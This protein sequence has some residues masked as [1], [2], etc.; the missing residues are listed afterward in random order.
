MLGSQLQDKVRGKKPQIGRTG[1]DMFTVS[2]VLTGW[3]PVI[4]VPVRREEERKEGNKQVHKT[5]GL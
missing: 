4:L 3:R 2:V 5:K 1:V